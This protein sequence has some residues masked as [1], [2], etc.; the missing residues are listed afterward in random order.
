ED[1]QPSF[2]EVFPRAPREAPAPLDIVL[3]EQEAARGGEVVL[4]IASDA[5]CPEC[6][7]TGFGFYGWCPACRGEGAVRVRERI[8]FR[9]PR[10]ADSGDV[11]LARAPSGA[12]VRA[13]IRVL[14]S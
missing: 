1:P 3:S 10:G 6:A 12:S 4:E 5:D 2:R 11:V 13:R 9:V 8:R 14:M 7:G